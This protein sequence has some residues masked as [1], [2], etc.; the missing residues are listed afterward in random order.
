MTCVVVMGVDVAVKHMTGGVLNKHGVY[1]RQDGV[2][3]DDRGEA[4]Y[5]VGVKDTHG[6]AYHGALHRAGRLAG[7][8]EEQQE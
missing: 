1:S 2:V 3:K 8:E 4:A 6:V 7:G 5:G